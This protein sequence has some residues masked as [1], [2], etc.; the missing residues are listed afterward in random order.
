M[1]EIYIFLHIYNTQKERERERDR[2]DGRAKKWT[3]VAC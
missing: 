3:R 1:D 2:E